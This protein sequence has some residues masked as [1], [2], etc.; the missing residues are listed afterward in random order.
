MTPT[1]PA[2]GEA[3]L[4]INRTCGCKKYGKRHPPLRLRLSTMLE[5][6]QCVNGGLDHMADRVFLTYRCGDCSEVVEITLR[7]LYLA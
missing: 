5:L 3:L 1:L 2:G 4:K 7:D 6:R